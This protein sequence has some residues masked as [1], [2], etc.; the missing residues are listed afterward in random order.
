MRDAALPLVAVRVVHM[1]ESARE[2]PSLSM[3]ASLCLP[4]DCDLLVDRSRDVGDLLDT[5]MSRSGAMPSATSSFGWDWPLPFDEDGAGRCLL[6]EVVE[7][8]GRMGLLK[9][10]ELSKLGSMDL[11]LPRL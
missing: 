3:S 6:P 7:G 10:G 2:H 4:A 11:C 1:V 5:V 9:Y 8:M